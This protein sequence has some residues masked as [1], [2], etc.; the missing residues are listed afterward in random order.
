MNTR[1]APDFGK[2]EL[3]ANESVL[4]AA[5][6]LRAAASSLAVLLLPKCPLCVAAYLTG[7]GV[8][9][10]A[11]YGAAPFVRPLAYLL[12]TVSWLALVSAPVARPKAP[13]AAFGHQR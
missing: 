1:K 6:T 8:S 11:A 10:G 4:K 13:L 7:L 3:G 5:R 9:T 2:F 12:A